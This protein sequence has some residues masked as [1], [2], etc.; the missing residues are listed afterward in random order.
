[1]I[2]LHFML[3]GGMGDLKFEKNSKKKL[4]TSIALFLNFSLPALRAPNR[5][6][7]VKDSS[8]QGDFAA[9]CITS[10]SHELMLS[11]DVDHQH[12]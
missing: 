5:H 6:H 1:M 11:D 4:I 7:K 9:W 10:R 12:V 3:R 8:S 2:I